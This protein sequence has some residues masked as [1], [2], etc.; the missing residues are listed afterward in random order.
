MSWHTAYETYPPPIPNTWDIA[1]FFIV[2][3]PPI[4][5]EGLTHESYRSFR[6]N[7]NTEKALYQLQVGS[8]E[9]FSI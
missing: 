5:R 3:P 6:E 7:L 2:L 9:Y 8:I 1:I 4:L